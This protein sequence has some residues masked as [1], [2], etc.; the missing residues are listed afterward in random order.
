MREGVAQEWLRNAI[1]GGML[2]GETGKPWTV[3]EVDATVAKYFDMFVL[4]LQGQALVKVAIYRELS[5]RF[6]ARS[7]S[8][9]ER[10]MS[11]ISAVMVALGY[12]HLRGLSPLA[13]YQRSLVDS[14]LNELGRR[15]SLDVFLV[16]QL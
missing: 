14:V 5:E 9:I 6:S 3:D 8:S 4:D 2:M 7:V 1:S 15:K 10:K 12:P 13:N 11:N 16:T